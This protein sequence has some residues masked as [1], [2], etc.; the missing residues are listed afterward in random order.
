MNSVFDDS[1][2]LCLA[3]AERIK[4]TSQIKVIFEVQDL[5]C[6]SLATI[7]R[8]GMVYILPTDLG[9]KTYLEPWSKNVKEDF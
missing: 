4:L 5:S 3:N 9:W 2:T 6:A 1:R 7:S 8:C